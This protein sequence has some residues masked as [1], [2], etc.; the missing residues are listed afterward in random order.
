MIVVKLLSNL[1][2]KAEVERETKKKVV[3]HHKRLAS[4][5]EVFMCDDFLVSTMKFYA[6]KL[7]D[8]IQ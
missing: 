6:T 5:H 4:A 7:T 1:G 8:M 3:E 2:A